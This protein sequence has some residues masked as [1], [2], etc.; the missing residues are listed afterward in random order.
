M[1]RHVLATICALGAL[2]MVSGS[3][4]LARADEVDSGCV[5]FE[6]SEDDKVIVYEAKNSCDEK[7]SCRMSWLLQCES[8]EGKV[9]ARSKKSASFELGASGTH[10]VSLSAEQCKQGWSIDDVSWSCKG[11]RQP[12]R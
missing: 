10:E 11:R 12:G 4:S 1:L 3:L 7:L 6:K 2:S 9:T 5:G 8:T